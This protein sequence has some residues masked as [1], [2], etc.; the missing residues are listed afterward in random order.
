MKFL[1]VLALL[2]A[3][4][5]FKCY[6]WECADLGEN[7][8]AEYADNVISVN[9]NGCSS[10]YTCGLMYADLQIYESDET[11]VE[12][13]SDAAY[14]AQE[15][16]EDYPSDYDWANSKECESDDGYNLQSGSFPKNCNSDEDCLLNNGKEA[17][18]WCGFN[19]VGYCM[20]SPQV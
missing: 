10:G 5:A 16:D 11:V 14:D 9:E 6:S 4:S 7:I 1:I 3:A 17:Q 20:P 13:I 19:G 18:C 8:C 12:C 15:D 2:G